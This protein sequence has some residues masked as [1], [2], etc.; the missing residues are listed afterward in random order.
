VLADCDD[1]H[2]RD[3]TGG[4]CDRGA[5]T[6]AGPARAD[7]TTARGSV[8]PKSTGPVHATALS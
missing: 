2:K 3:D 8:G 5:P 6:P 1:T 7:W 4:D